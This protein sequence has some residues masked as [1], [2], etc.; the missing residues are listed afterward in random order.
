MSLGAAQPNPQMNVTVCEI[1]R[2]YARMPRALA[3]VA[4]AV[5]SIFVAARLYSRICLSRVAR[6]RRQRCE[7]FAIVNRC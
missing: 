1:L 7:V 5:S 6:R 4:L 2:L 3:F